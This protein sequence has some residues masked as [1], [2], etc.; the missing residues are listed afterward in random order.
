MRT[1]DEGAVR[2]SSQLCRILGN[3]LAYRIVRIL[4]EGRRRPM[5]LA[6]LLGVSASAVVNQLRHLKIAGVVRFDSG[7]VRRGGRRVDYFLADPA[8]ARRLGDL[9]RTVKSLG[10]STFP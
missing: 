7:G 5:H 3:P 4:G 2:R 6:R 10:R 8:L 1:T 9:E